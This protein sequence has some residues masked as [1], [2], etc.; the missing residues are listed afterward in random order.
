MECLDWFFCNTNIVRNNSVPT[1]KP[2]NSVK[3]IGIDKCDFCG[4]YLQIEQSCLIRGN[5]FNF[6]SND[7]W[8]KF[9]NKSD[10]EIII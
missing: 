5:C 6:C 10:E 9:L 4:T 1:W 8:N 2:V 3:H 7:C